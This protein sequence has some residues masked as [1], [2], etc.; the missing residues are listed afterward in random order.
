M[1][2][3]EKGVNLAAVVLPFLATI[4]AIVLLWNQ[5]VGWTD[6]AVAAFMYAITAFGI[7]IGYHRMLTHRSF[8]TSK[9][10][11]YL[12]AALGSMAVQGPVLS[13]V[14]DHRKHHAHTDVEG[15]PH[16]PH[17]GHGDGIRG[18]FAGL[19]HAHVGWLLSTQGRA[20]WKRYARDLYEDR[21]MR[22]I[23]RHFVSFVLLTLAL[24]ALLGFLLTG[25]LLGALTGLLWGGLVRIFF[26]H[27][28]TWSVNSVCHFLG[29]RRFET[30]DHSTNVAW[31]AVPSLGEAW[32]HNHHAFPRSARHG[33]RRFEIDPT[34]GVIRLMEMA[35]IA[36]NVVRIS[37]ERQAERERTAGPRP[38]AH[39]QARG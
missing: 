29:S 16:S 32:H 10:V 12:F 1:S 8:Q 27:H 4:T 39:A 33:L 35:G 6:L 37:P 5:A 20:D 22:F 18:V 25:T 34:W 11:E 19:V 26:V 3:V 13:W 24:P 31:L 28:I 2:R 15:D 7:T 9:P 23:S 14:A 36:R 17:V 30:D 21:G 38:A